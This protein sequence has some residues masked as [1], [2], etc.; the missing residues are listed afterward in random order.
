MKTAKEMY[1]YC[2][3]NKY[4]SG[5]SKGQSLKHFTLIENMLQA[6]ENILFAFIG[7]H[8]YVSTTQH[9]NNFAYAITD[10]RIL[11]A[12]KKVVGQATQVV[13]LQNVNDITFTSGFI[14]GIITIDTTKECFNIAVDKIT[15]SNIFKKLY[16]VFFDLKSTPNATS[17]S[18]VQDISAIDQ[19]KEF[20]ELLDLGI[21]TQEEFNK[22]K[23]QILN[24]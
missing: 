5:F 17:K 8:N 16:S 14:Y 20:K 10:T 24:L 3:D 15:A 7:L 9:D 21:I 19:I 13:S 23:K 11:M 22:K 2:T 4:G 12:Q 1:Q 18:I 6:N